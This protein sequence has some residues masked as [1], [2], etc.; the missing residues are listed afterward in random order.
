MDKIVRETHNG[1]HF[2]LTDTPNPEDRD[3]IHQ[4]IKAFNNAV[5][6]HHRA[7]RRSGP[8]PLDIFI[9]D[10]QGRLLGGLVASTYW[11]WLD[12]EDLWL[13]ETLRGLGYGREL[14]AIVET[15]ALARGCSRVFLQTF[16]FQA[17]GFYEKLGYQVVGRLDD[18]PP[19]QTFF[20]M[21]KDF[22]IV[23]APR[24]TR[25]IDES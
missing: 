8:K 17:K 16:S 9:C 25:G 22:Q 23:R 12:I 6:E 18:Y 20:W 19:G 1:L 24:F 10:S 14:L 15:E 4:R 13:D 2:T 3:Y 21:R 7:V 11:G 5:S